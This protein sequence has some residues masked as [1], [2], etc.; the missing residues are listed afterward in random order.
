MTTICLM[1]SDTF[2]S[3]RVDQ[4]VDCG[5]WNVVPLLFNGCAKLLDIGGNWNTLLYMSI[6]SIPNKLNGWHVWWVCRPWKNWDN[7]SF[8]VLCTDRCDIGLCIITLKHEVMAAHE[9]HDN[10]PQ[11]LITISLCIQIAIDK[12]QLCSLSVAYACPYHNPTATMGY[13]VYSV[14]STPLALTTPY[15]LSAICLVQLKP[16]IHLRRAHFSSMPVAIVGEHLITEL[17]AG[18]TPNC[19]QVKTLVRTTS[20]QMSFPETI[21]DNLCIHSSIVQA[22]RFFSGPGGWCQTILPVKKP[23]VQVLGRRGCTWSGVV[24]PVGR[25]A[26][27]SKTTFG[28]AYG[29]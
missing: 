16:G 5:L 1:Q 17:Q 4:A 13:S 27:F 7:F 28:A 8:Q 12:M 20:T 29:R 14:I 15:T 24:S 9:W 26:K 19:S 2:P 3:H 11:E 21:S 6:Q 25:T 23:D 10:G 22:H 18:Q